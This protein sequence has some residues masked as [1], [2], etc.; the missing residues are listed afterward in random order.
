MTSLCDHKTVCEP[1]DS[2]I[3]KE[4]QLF[5][6]VDDTCIRH[7]SHKILPNQ[8]FF[9]LFPLFLFCLFFLGNEP[10]RSSSALFR[11]PNKRNIGRREQTGRLL[12][13]ARSI[14]R[15]LSVER[16]Y[17]GGGS[18]EN[19]I[20]ATLRKEVFQNG[21]PTGTPW[22]YYPTESGFTVQST[23]TNSFVL[24]AKTS[25]FIWRIEP[26]RHHVPRL[27]NIPFPSSDTLHLSHFTGRN[28]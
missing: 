17:L 5:L 25:K 6:S 2:V 28:E 20:N 24:A 9:S 21:S 13:G 15:Q 1:G 14:F 18:R 3:R 7:F 26:F 27:K 22:C 19:R 16:L 12:P 4:Q 8:T 10:Q 11:T 23:G